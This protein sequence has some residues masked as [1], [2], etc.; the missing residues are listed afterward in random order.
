MSG[1]GLSDGLP[2]RL[3]DTARGLECAADGVPADAQDEA[4]D[5]EREVL[6]ALGSKHRLEVSQE[7]R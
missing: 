5:Q 7:G 4:K 1:E 2:S 6:E 3:L